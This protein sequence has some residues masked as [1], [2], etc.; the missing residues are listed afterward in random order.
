MPLFLRGVWKI[1]SGGKQT[2]RVHVMARYCLKLAKPINQSHWNA[3]AAPKGFGGCGSYRVTVFCASWAIC[4]FHL[5]EI[6]GST[7][8]NHGFSGA[9]AGVE[10]KAIIMS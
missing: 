9:R 3:R 4:H 5:Q 7:A 6:V 8:G 10:L 1:L 2:E